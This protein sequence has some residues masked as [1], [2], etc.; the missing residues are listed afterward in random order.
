MKLLAKLVFGLYFL[1]GVVSPSVSAGPRQLRSPNNENGLTIRVSAGGWGEGSIQ[2]IEKVLYSAA[3]EIFAYAPRQREISIVVRHTD[4]TPIT[5]YE[6]GPKGEFIVLL[7]AKDTYW[8]QYAYQFSHEFCHVLAMNSKVTGDP[9]QWFEESLGETASL[10]ALR[11]MATT[12][13]T[14]PPYPNWKDYAPSL[15]NYAQDLINESY[16]KLP[17][18][19][20]LA[21]WFEENETSLRKNPYLRQK[22]GL[23]AN[24]LLTLLEREPE[25]WMAVAYLNMSRPSRNEAFRDY[26]KTWHDHVPKRY[27]PFVER[28][29]TMFG[30][31]ITD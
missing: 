6:R 18:D 31:S 7:T 21:E 19:M 22:D 17:S 10:F 1:L 11:K 5:L 12:W 3:A 4:D 29:A 27:E 24:Q 30:V 16:R 14:S 25:N 28:I 8:S 20:T 15:H 9:N 2:D 13:A 23:V 26:L